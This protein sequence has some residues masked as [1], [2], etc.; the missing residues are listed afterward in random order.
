MKAV[1]IKQFGIENLA[2]TELPVPQP[3]KGEV[4]VR[5]TAAALQYLDLIVINGAVM[6]DLKLPHIP[7]SEGAGIVEQTGEG[8]SKWKPGDRVMIHFVQEWISG[9]PHHGTNAIRTGLQV[10]GTLTEYLCISSEAL[11]RSPANLSDEEASTLG[12]SGLT[13]WTNLVTLAGI[14]PGQTVLTQGTGGVS[15]AALQFAKA[16]G[17]RVIATT[18]SEDKRQKLKQLGADEVINYKTNHKWSDEVL[19]LN[20]GRGV[21]ITLDMGGAA[22][23]EQ[24][25]LSMAMGGYVGLTGFLGGAS[26]TFQLAPAIMNYV[27]LQGNSVGSRSDFED[28]V[29]AIEINNIKPVLG[30]VVP[31]NEFKKGFEALKKGQVFGKM[32]ISIK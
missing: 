13:A 20:N 7:V 24:S 27:R 6:P 28:M 3:Q 16:A 21:D 23:L 19:Q 9:N 2:V 32:V 18:G 11:V 31:F 5:M 12:V 8:V 15:L 4:L 30:M 1:Q 17:A 14:K 29:D 10:Q 26:V 22:S 25:I